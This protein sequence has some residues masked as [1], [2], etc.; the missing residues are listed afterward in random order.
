MVRHGAEMVYFVNHPELLG[1]GI[2]LLF[3]SAGSEPAMFSVRLWSKELH[4]RA[5]RRGYIVDR[6]GDGV[7]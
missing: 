2:A 3:Y 1:E 5:G 4:K 6:D 7:I